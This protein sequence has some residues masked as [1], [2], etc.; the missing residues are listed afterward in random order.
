MCG[1][2]FR[3][4]CSAAIGLAICFEVYSVGGCSDYS[5]L[6]GVGVTGVWTNNEEILLMIFVWR[7]QRPCSSSES[8]MSIITAGEEVWMVDDMGIVGCTGLGG[9][10]KVGKVRA[11]RPKP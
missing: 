6:V 9:C 8:S 3:E 7:P 10:T 11:C 1:F 5:G 4:S 2:V